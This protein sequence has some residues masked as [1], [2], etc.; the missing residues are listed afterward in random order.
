MVNERLTTFVGS[1]VTAPVILAEPWMHPSSAGGRRWP[2]TC[3][4]PS[5]SLTVWRVRVV[6]EFCTGTLG[7]PAERLAARGLLGYA[8]EQY[9]AP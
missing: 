3:T 2:T 7:I 1:R 4:S 8:R 5:A 6:P 9:P